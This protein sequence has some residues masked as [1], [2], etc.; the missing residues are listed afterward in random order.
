LQ[1]LDDKITDLEEKQKEQ[2][3]IKLGAERGIEN[4]EDAIKLILQQ[5]PGAGRDAA[6]EAL[7]NQLD[8]KVK[9]RDQADLELD[10]IKKSIE[11]TQEQVK[12][13]E[14]ELEDL[15]KTPCP[16]D[17]YTPTPTSTSCSP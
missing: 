10:K 17:T 12:K 9:I 16:T 14:K 3:S 7:N 4:V 15:M 1:T 5:P 8:Q 6:L 2:E 11:E 13:K